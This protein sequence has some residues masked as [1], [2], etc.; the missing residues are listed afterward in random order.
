MERLIFI[1]KTSTTNYL[2]YII[3]FKGFQEQNRNIVLQEIFEDTKGV[4]RNRKSI[5]DRQQNGQQDK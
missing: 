1:T 4:T 2:N 5:E 3:G